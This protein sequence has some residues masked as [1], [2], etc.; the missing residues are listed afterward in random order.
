MARL[1]TKRDEDFLLFLRMGAEGTRR[2][3]DYLSEPS[4]GA[5][6]VRVL[7]R[8]A[9]VPKIWKERVKRLRVPDIFCLACGKRVEV[10]AKSSPSFTMSHSETQ[11]GREWDS[12]LREA[13]YAAFVVVERV[14]GKLVADEL[15]QF[16]QVAD[17][18]KAHRNGYIK[19]L[20]RKAAA[21][22]AE[23]QL[24]WP[25][26]FAKDS[27]KVVNISFTDP[28]G[29]LT[30][31]Y[32]SRAKRTALRL[33][34]RNKTVSGVQLM[35]QVKEGQRFGKHQALAS[36]V[37]VVQNFG[38]RPKLTMDDYLSMAREFHPALQHTG[39]RA[40]GFFKGS[41]NPD[42]LDFLRSV[43]SKNADPLVQV[44]AA[45]SLAH[46]EDECGLEWLCQTL[47]GNAN[48]TTAVR[49]ECVHALTELTNAKAIRALTQTVQ[50]AREEGIRAAAA[51]ALGCIRPAVVDNEVLGTLIAT[52]SQ[53]QEQVR[54]EAVRALSRLLDDH[55]PF[56]LD[57]LDTSSS[58]ERAGI[59]WAIGHGQT[60]DAIAQ[61]LQW[62]M[63]GTHDQEAKT[64]AAYVLALKDVLQTA[65]ALEMMRSLQE[66]E[67]EL[68]FAIMVLAQIM[69]SW[70][71]RL[72]D[73]EA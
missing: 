72:E 51:W 57:Q 2:V 58:E 39:I 16:V 32:D 61:V 44:E 13:D 34:R 28:D 25:T 46:L 66:E 64:W 71:Y 55:L 60:A 48:A 8:G 30:V 54:V 52:F 23:E 50:N 31:Q 15:V 4:G 35:P 67:P 12:G 26:L 68:Y 9:L 1:F 33:T 45:L 70:V 37:P 11:Q 43:L 21:D 3:C 29:R 36:V 18:Q 14:N 24:E 20:S 69:K 65:P 6:S 38:C 63:T 59:A 7:D 62:I 10:R 53:A 40:L 5:H 17:M 42:V 73:T 49:F 56:L 41:A 27:G 47:A 22:A 19:R